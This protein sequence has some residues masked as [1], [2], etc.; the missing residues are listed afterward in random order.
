V[1]VAGPSVTKS[2]STNIEH[3]V[4]LGAWPGFRMPDLDGIAPW[5]RA[6]DASDR[7][8]S[9][10]YYD[11]DDLRLV[12]AGVTIRH[13]RG[14]GGAEGRWTAKVPVPGTDGEERTEV[15]VDA[16]PDHMPSEVAAVLRGVL[17]QG[18]LV[19]A[20]RL[21]TRRHLV[22]LRDGGGRL[23]GEVADDEVSVLEGD[24]I[25]ARFREVEVEVVPGAPPALISLV[26]DHLR[27]AGAGDA[28]TTPKLVRALGPRALAPPD[29]PVPSL[30]RDPSA[31][32]VVRAAIALSVQRL[33]A[34][35]PVI[36]LDAGDV[37]VH[38]AR[39]STRRLRSDLKTFGSLV[40]ADWADGLRNDLKVLADAL[41]AV[42]DK[43]VLGQ[44]LEAAARKLDRSDEPIAMRLVRRLARQRALAHA[45]LLDFL[46]SPEYTALLDRLV[47]AGSD[48]MLTDAAD[49]PATKVFPE[50][51]SMPWRKL[52]KAVDR[53]GHQ[54]SD[55]EL[56]HVRI[57]AKRARYAAEA[58]APALPAGAKHGSALANL[59]TVLGDQHDAV[60]A[61]EWLRQAVSDGTSR[62][63]AFVAGLLVAAE[64]ADAA[65]HRQSWRSAWKA[66]SRPK[67]TGWLRT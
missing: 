24:R 19:V 22:E 65:N 35:D 55:E 12:R 13:R 57:L 28:D 30:G 56:H 37:G 20:A 54:P 32:L 50:L 34:H 51:V 23:L 8:L 36:R 39:V 26:V 29:P 66:A 21:V 4:K 41:G 53:L 25:A 38:Q 61:E 31:A 46:S 10:T 45:D 11:T 9:A 6:T 42:R 63:Q 49:A 62:S 14:E 67:V 40:E 48:P 3:E 5:V 1:L 16:G 43:D 33:L 47:A 52:R 64:R 60:V 7:E 18:T 44:R 58:A 59:Q 27:A 17:R 15:S 2:V